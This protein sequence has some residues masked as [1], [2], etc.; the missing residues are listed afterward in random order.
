MSS[1]R[2][3]VKK[4]IETSVDKVVENA[5]DG[6][7]D[8]DLMKANFKAE[9]EAEV[10]SEMKA[11]LEAEQTAYKGDKLRVHLFGETPR[12]SEIGNTPENI[13][14]WRSLGTI[15]EF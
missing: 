9:L 13:A 15:S 4:V 1:N 7:S 5:V 6:L 12:Q 3:T 2:K 10:R 11:E 8:R 14:I